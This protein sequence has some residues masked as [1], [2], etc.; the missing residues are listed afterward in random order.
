MKLNPNEIATLFLAPMTILASLSTVAIHSAFATLAAFATLSAL[1]GA[2]TAQDQ[3][4]WGDTH[5]H[6]SNSIDAYLFGNMTADPE[7]AY[8]FAKGPT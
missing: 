5:L 2:A 3:L 7:T 1:A 6:S 8:R 4:L